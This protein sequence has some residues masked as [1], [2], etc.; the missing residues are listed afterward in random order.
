MRLIQNICP[1]L[2]KLDNY[3]NA[4]VTQ[5][6]EENFMARSSKNPTKLGESLVPLSRTSLDTKQ[7]IKPHELTFNQAFD[8]VQG[9]LTLV[10][11]EHEL[12]M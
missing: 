12:V 3:S 1:K 10:D 4:H 8:L 11:E 2:K 9:K 7:V 5:L 6:E